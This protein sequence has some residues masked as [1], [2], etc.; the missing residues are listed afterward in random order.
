MHAVEVQIVDSLIAHN[1]IQEAEIIHT[2]TGGQFKVIAYV[3]F[4]L[5]INT[6]LTEFHVRRR[7]C[8]TIVPISQ[9][10]RFR[11]S[12][13]LEILEAGIAIISGSVTH[14]RV[15]RFLTFV[16]DTCRQFMSSQVIGEVIHNSH[17]CILHQVVIGKQL[18]TGSHVRL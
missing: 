6:Q 14:I 2:Y 17:N 15:P 13:I 1:I 10:K 16:A 9:G 7:F 11:C 12:F 5:Q 3:P 8:I 4:I 18:V